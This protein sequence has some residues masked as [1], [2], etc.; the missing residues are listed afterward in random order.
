MKPERFRVLVLLAGGLINVREA[1]DAL[2]ATRAMKFA[3]H[4]RKAL[5]W[6]GICAGSL[7]LIAGVVAEGNNWNP[8]VEL[9]FGCLPWNG[10]TI[11][12]HLHA[13]LWTLF[14]GL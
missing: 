4:L 1:E 2:F 12:R 5:F 8:W 10:P 11:A 14:G 3:R 9:R 6:G 13:V 7:L